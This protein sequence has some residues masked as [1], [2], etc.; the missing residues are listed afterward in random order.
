MGPRGGPEL[1][2][3]NESAAALQMPNSADGET[4]RDFLPILL[5]ALVYRWVPLYR[6]VLNPY[7]CFVFFLTQLQTHLLSGQC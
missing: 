2:G 3:F 7:S 5:G 6:N 1:L 4:E